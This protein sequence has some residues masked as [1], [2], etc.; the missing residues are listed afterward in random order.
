MPGLI[1]S[2]RVNELSLEW[3]S[4]L[5]TYIVEG[6]GV[7]AFFGGGSWGPRRNMSQKQVLMVLLW[8]LDSSQLKKKI[9]MPTISEHMNTIYGW[10][11][12]H[13]HTD[14]EDCL[15]HYALNLE[16]QR[17]LLREMT[18]ADN[19]EDRADL[20]GMYSTAVTDGSQLLAQLKRATRLHVRNVRDSVTILSD[21]VI[22]EYDDI[23]D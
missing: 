23:F 9:K 13:V 1:L 5:K 12:Y 19:K 22:P 17:W 16:C 8:T 18:K 21:D 7:P 6:Y 10:L 15:E 3:F 2:K 14:V 20:A 11:N 4:V